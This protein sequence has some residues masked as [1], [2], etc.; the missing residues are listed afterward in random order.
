M[1]GV[2]AVSEVSLSLAPGEVLGLMGPNG[3]GKSTLLNL[4]AGALRP[5]TGRI[6][7]DG[8]DITG[9]PSHQVCGKGIARTFQLVRPF[10]GLSVTENVLVGHRPRAPGRPGGPGEPRAEPPPV[11]T[12]RRDGVPGRRRDS[13]MSRPLRAPG[14]IP[15]GW[16]R[17]IGRETFEGRG[18]IVRLPPSANRVPRHIS[19]RARLRRRALSISFMVSAFKL[20]SRR[21]SRPVST[22]RI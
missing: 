16:A 13:T 21:T 12:R 20:P 19:T 10:T 7:L 2:G 5:E 1:G 14:R 6:H 3:S 11:T 17:R 18:T 8:D 15:P 4:I 9:L 22:E